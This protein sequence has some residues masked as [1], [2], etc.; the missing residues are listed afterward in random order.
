MPEKK[1]VQ[2]SPLTSSKVRGWFVRMI[3]CGVVFGN[4]HFGARKGVPIFSSCRISVRL[5]KRTFMLN[6]SQRLRYGYVY[7][8]FI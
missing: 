3:E 2:V 7:R 5:T 6:D 8:K 4:Q 1:E